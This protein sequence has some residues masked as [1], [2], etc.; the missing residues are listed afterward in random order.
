M[1]S[2]ELEYHVPSTFKLCCLDVP[3]PVELYIYVTLLF[4]IWNI[5]YHKSDGIFN[6]SYL[7][8]ISYASF[9]IYYFHFDTMWKKTHFESF[10]FE[11]RKY[12]TLIS[13]NC[14]MEKKTYL[15]NSFIRSRFTL[16]T[17]DICIH[18]PKAK[19]TKCVMLFKTHWYAYYL[20]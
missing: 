16:F 1:V 13:E 18:T 17:I 8:A 12:E 19:A 7:I 6:N 14:M 9:Q 20:Y 10:W 11:E 4:E 2:S 15:S 5:F 3:D